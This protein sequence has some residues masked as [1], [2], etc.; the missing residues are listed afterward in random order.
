MRHARVQNRVRA[1]RAHCSVDP[2]KR[3][4]DWLQR[5]L[6]AAVELEF[7]TIPPYLAAL[8]SIED[9]DS[10]VARS[11]REVVQEEMVHMATACNLLVALERTPDLLS[12]VPRYPG[13]PPFDVLQSLEVSLRPLDAT[14]IDDFVTLE[15]PEEERAGAAG[16]FYSIGDFYDEVIATLR[17]LAPTLRYEEQIHGHLSPMVVL[18][19]DDAV[20]ALERIKHQGEGSKDKPF[21]TGLKDLTHYWRFREMQ[22]K[23]EYRYDPYEERWKFMQAIDMPDVY[24]MKPIPAGGFDPEP[25]PPVARLL[26]DFDRAYSSLLRQLQAAWDGEGQSALWRGFEGMFGM[27]DLAR[28]LMRSPIP[29]DPGYSYGPMF[30]FVP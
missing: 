16:K 1:L 7:Y 4:L 30:Q 6:Q 19:I 10:Y 17:T 25:A 23:K 20:T 15:A 5:A 12:G 22:I 2:D 18:S 27:R 29:S 9:S 3:D 14:A 8:W 11:L 26:R 28:E 21:D 13:P 24:P